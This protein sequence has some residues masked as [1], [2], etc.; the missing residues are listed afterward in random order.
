MKKIALKFTFIL[1]IVSVV[2]CFVHT[3]D[4]LAVNGE[5]C[6]PGYWKQD[7]HF[8]TWIAPLTPDTLFSDVFEDAFPGKTLLDVLNQGGGKLNAL[9]RHA[10]AA[11][12]NAASPDVAYDLSPDEVIDL[13]NAAFPGGGVS[14]VKDIFEGFNEQGA[15][16]CEPVEAC[17]CWEDGLLSLIPADFTLT[18]CGGCI[19]SPPNCPDI[20]FSMSGPSNEI[21]N[22]NVN[23][24][25]PLGYVCEYSIFDGT[26][27]NTVTEDITESLASMCANDMLEAVES[28]GGFCTIEQ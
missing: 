15:L 4:V 8:D 26:N 20:G 12:L 10:V 23:P 6:T 19:I 11:L 24:S 25:A 28:L 21:L 17:P 7:Q 3:N 1:L 27:W 18:S 16:L 13:F 22:V 2:V 5:G 9:G 14:G